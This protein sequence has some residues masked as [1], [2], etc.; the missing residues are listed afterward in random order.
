VDENR[1]WA[2]IEAAW[3]AAGGKAKSRQRLAE[4]E[5]F[6]ASRQFLGTSL[7]IEYKVGNPLCSG[8][9]R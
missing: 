4:G 9:S 7:E 6:H 1:F 3:G 8:T 2:M 5:L